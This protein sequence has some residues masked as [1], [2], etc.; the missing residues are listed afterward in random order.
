MQNSLSLSANADVPL[1]QN[2]VISTKSL[3]ERLN[4]TK[5]VILANAKKCLPNKVIEHGKATF[6]NKAE[7]TVILDYMKNHASNNRSVE[8]NSTVANTS[9]D[10]TPALKIKKALE[11]MQEG[12]EEELAILRAKNA[13]KQALLDRIAN[14][15]G[16][17]SMNQT[18]KA[19]KLPYG[20]ITLFEKL[21]GMQILNLDNTPKQEQINN[22]NFKVVVKFINEKV[23]NKTVT[24]TTG[25]GLV[26]LARKFNTEIDESVQA[27][28]GES[29]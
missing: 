21:R 19:L 23:G 12:Y 8:L 3:A 14:G 9:T 16:C 1:A 20:N 5:D 13:E 2:D 11:L 27:D 6:W 10:L 29:A 25:K 28:M 4:T 17:Y 22:G 26:Y 18:A 15:K 24:L 7:V